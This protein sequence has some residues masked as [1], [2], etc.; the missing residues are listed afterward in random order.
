MLDDDGEPQMDMYIDMAGST[1]TGTY[2]DPP[3]QEACCGGTY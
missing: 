3:S 2:W 1:A